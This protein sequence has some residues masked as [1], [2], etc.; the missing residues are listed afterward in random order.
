MFGKKT[1]AD[2]KA[3]L[4]LY[5]IDRYDGKRSAAKKMDVSVDTLTKYIHDFEEE[6]GTQLLSS[7][8]GGC[9]L[10]SHGL[11]FADYA[12]EIEHE[13]QHMYTLVAERDEVKGEVRLLWDHNI[14]ANIMMAD[15]WT[16]FKKHKNIAIISN[17]FDSTTD[18]KNFSYDIAL[19]YR[20]PPGNEWELIY[21]SPV[22]AKFFASTSYLKKYGY[23]MDLNDM[24]E[25]HRM[26]F[27]HDCDEWLKNGKFLLEQAKHKIYISDTSFMV[28]DAVRNGI[29]I[30]ILPRSFSRTGLVC[31]D[32]IKCEVT[33][34]IYV[35]AH[36]DFKSLSR[37]K[38]VGEYIKEVLK[39]T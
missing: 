4:F 10:T 5:A 6:C 18:I 26:V 15:L 39:G 21:S 9:R 36:R 8:A 17:S 35:I 13:L 27:K 34:N 16:L 37:V 24:L 1:L 14:R 2:L 23:P 38:I 20:L 25:N 30:G 3:V 32:N 33:A 11:R 31:L 12:A 19:C 28:N 7:N 22:R 29:G